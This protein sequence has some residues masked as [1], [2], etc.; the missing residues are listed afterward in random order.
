M[1]KIGER[2][3]THREK[4]GLTQ[5]ELGEKIGMLTKQTVSKWERGVN[6]P[7]IVYL[8][9]LAN[10]FGCTID[11]LLG[12]IPGKYWVELV[13]G[14]DVK[15]GQLFEN[16][17]FNIERKE[18]HGVTI[19]RVMS[20]VENFPE[21]IQEYILPQRLVHVHYGRKS[22]INEDFDEIYRS[23]EVSKERIWSNKYHNHSEFVKIWKEQSE[24]GLEPCVEELLNDINSSCDSATNLLVE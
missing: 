21:K 15:V 14:R 20:Y 2:I 8:P 19:V 13:E 5:D 6:Y 12:Y 18:E 17:E 4:L 11:S 10:L 16:R 24:L 7:E 22:D 1:N 23:Y 9:A 3:R